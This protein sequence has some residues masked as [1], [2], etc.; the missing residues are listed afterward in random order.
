MACLSGNYTHEIVAKCLGLEINVPC[1]MGSQ[2]VEDLEHIT[3]NCKHVGGTLD[4]MSFWVPSPRFKSFEELK[5]KFI[6]YM[7]TID[8]RELVYCYA[9]YQWL[10]NNSKKHNR[11]INNTKVMAMHIMEAI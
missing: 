6:S 11:S 1:P 10:H 9:T 2:N 7:D 8:S 5:R 4:M 3:T